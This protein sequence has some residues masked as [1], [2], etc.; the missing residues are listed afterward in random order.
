MTLG[1]VED[2]L[3]NLRKVKQFYNRQIAMV[4]TSIR[5]HEKIENQIRNDQFWTST[6]EEDAMETKAES[7]IRYPKRQK[8]NKKIK[9][10]VKKRI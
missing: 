3:R 8:I 5:E 1:E 7:E 6:D 10:K 9:I 2:L 4:S